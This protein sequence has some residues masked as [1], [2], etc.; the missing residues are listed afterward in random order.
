MRDWY[1]SK[2]DDGWESFEGITFNGKPISNE[3]LI[4]YFQEL[5]N[6]YLDEL[7]LRRISS[8]DAEELLHKLQDRHLK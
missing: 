4:A 7:E 6:R 5:E 8:F 3:K 2:Y 1:V